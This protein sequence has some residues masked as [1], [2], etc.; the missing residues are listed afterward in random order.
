MHSRFCLN[1]PIESSSSQSHQ[2]PSKW[3][4][5][6]GQEPGRKQTG[7]QHV[8]HK[9]PHPTILWAEDLKHQRNYLGGGGETSHHTHHFYCKSRKVGSPPVPFT[10]RDTN[11]HKQLR[12]QMG[13]VGGDH[14]R[15]LVLTSQ[16]CRDK[17][18]S[19][20]AIQTTGTRQECSQRFPAHRKLA[21]QGA[22]AGWLKLFIVISFR[23]PRNILFFRKGGHCWAFHTS[24]LKQ[25]HPG[26]QASPT[27]LLINIKPSPGAYLPG[28]HLLYLA[29]D[30]NFW[31]ERKRMKEK[32]GD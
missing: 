25:S 8:P 1:T 6:R 24:T 7:R 20:C 18:T 23:S 16:Q 9:P 26:P 27:F 14:S 30:T 32:A 28:E 29:R 10:S 31:R 19:K 11:L 12:I 13:V 5:C 22:M 17:P 3:G 4:C 2:K 15:G 21:G